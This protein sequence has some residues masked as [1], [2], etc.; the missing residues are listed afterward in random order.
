MPGT[1][2][3]VSTPIGNYADL[4]L[5]A[6]RALR[7]ADYVICEEFKEAAK[8]LRFFDIKKELKSLNEHNEA[9]SAE[10]YFYDILNGKNVALISDCGTPLF[11]DPGSV[12][13]RKCI[14]FSI[15]VDF[16]P[17]ANSVL[18]ALVISGFDISRF[19]FIG[20][21]SPKTEIRKRELNE[22]RKLD[23]VFVLMDTPYRLKALLQD[24]D[25]AFR[26]RKL[27]IGFNLTT[28]KEKVFRGTANDILAE[29][30][31][32]NLKGEF[33]IIINKE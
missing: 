30:G 21:L 33:V 27:C 17:G 23:R 28:E 31:E 2:Y 6:L 14:D 10:E 13:L 25:S 32:E 12:L 16:I 3:I 8:L 29:I 1:L 15:P 24:I 11:A 7:E 22:L 5:R 18:A 19:Y 26:E 9:E 4:T 20:F